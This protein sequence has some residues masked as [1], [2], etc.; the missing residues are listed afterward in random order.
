MLTTQNFSLKKI[1]LTDSPPDITVLNFNWD[2]ID[3]NMKEALDK[4]RSWDEFLKNGGT[5]MGTLNFSK[6]S[7]ATIDEIK[8]SRDILCFGT[9]NREVVIESK[10]LRPSLRLSSELSLGRPDIPWKDVHLTGK[11]IANTGYSKLPNGLILQWG[12]VTIGAQP[13]SFAEITITLPVAINSYANMGLINVHPAQTNLA[14]PW[15]Y[16]EDMKTVGCIKTNST[17]LIRLF[18]GANVPS[19]AGGTVFADLK[20]TLISA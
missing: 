8:T 1:E 19:P 12:Q 9:S 5:L 7:T 15:S 4:A 13:G 16:L 11:S 3:M 2:T 17:M 10:G 6:D 14:N 18:V 20:W